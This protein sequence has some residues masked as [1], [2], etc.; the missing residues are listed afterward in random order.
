MKKSNEERCPSACAINFDRQKSGPRR[1]ESSAPIDRRHF[2]STLARWKW[3]EQQLLDCIHQVSNKVLEQD[4]IPQTET[5][6]R[7]DPTYF[8][9]REESIEQAFEFISIRLHR[10]HWRDEFREQRQRHLQS[11]TEIA[12]SNATTTT[13]SL[14]T[15]NNCN[16]HHG[17]RSS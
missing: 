17:S 4:S 11:S 9:R 8:E 15:T 5:H 3:F 12:T 2:V 6:T 10:C 13:A 7:I 16:Q 1:G 14:N